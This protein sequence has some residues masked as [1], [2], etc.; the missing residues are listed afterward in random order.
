M[1][2]LLNAVRLPESI[3]DMRTPE[4]ARLAAEIR[5][6]LVTTVLRTGGHLASNLGVV[7]LTLALYKVFD[8]P[9]D[10]IIW[11]VGHQAYVH[12]ILSGRKGMFSTLRQSGGLS[13]FPK[14]SE[15]PYDAFDT[16]HSSTSISAALGIARARDIVGDKYRVIA[17]TG[18]GALT[19]GLCYEAMNDAGHAATDL[20]V[21]LNDNEMSISD[22]VGSVSRH[23]SHIRSL[24]MYFSL[25]DD[26]HTSLEKIPAIGRPVASFISRIKELLKYSIIPGVL[27]EELGFRYIGPVDGHSIDELI[28]ILNGV[29]AMRGP[30]LVHVLTKKGMGFPHAESDP[31]KYHGVSPRTFIEDSLPADTEAPAASAVAADTEESANGAVAA[32]A[33]TNKKAAGFSDVFGREL[34]KIA[35]SDGSI[36]AISA[37]M[38]SGVGLDA[39]AQKFPGRFFDVGIAEQHA[40]TLAAGMSLYGLRPVAAL[41]STF[42]QRAYDQAVHD[43]CLQN[44]HVVIAIDRAGVVGEDGETHQGIYDM[45][46]LRHM[47]N[48]TIMA[49][50][51]SAEL[52]EML[53]YALY[54]VEGPV[55]IRYP[56]D[57]V[58]YPIGSAHCPIGSAHNPDSSN[59]SANAGQCRSGEPCAADYSGAKK[60]LSGKGELLQEGADITIVSVGIMLA[61]AQEAARELSSR[62]YGV[63]LI[64]A[65]FIK[66]VD[67]GLISESVKK[68]GRLLVAEDGCTAGGF[69]SAVIE[70]LSGAGLS[71]QPPSAGF[72]ERLSGICFTARLC[73]LPDRP[74]E[75]GVRAAVLSKYGLDRDGLLKTA[76]SML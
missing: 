66:P 29:A 4:L 31:K 6:F 72:P 20:I 60:L 58:H 22:N 7:E 3:K 36:V 76:M 53:R 34:I 65:R 23:L 39:F 52:P 12:K 40:L 51:D 26:I 16:G 46:F 24:P 35:E 71:E 69:G 18:D 57:S 11:D 75:Q 19:G 5:E 73:G 74:I 8:L 64:S 56:K 41:Y 55:A 44:A 45:A 32:N 9:N 38:T 10:K 61:P 63:D 21:V 14:R 28:N 67:I 47:P 50:S 15:S 70:Q 17:V 13:G 33:H 68:T 48:M 59:R 54:D 42:L 30:L 49:P 2:N 27:F 43:I 1:D 37:A 25:R 62:G